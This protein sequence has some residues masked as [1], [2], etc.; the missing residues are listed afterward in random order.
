MLFAHQVLAL[1]GPGFDEGGTRALRILLL[2]QAFNLACGPV[3]N[4][5]MMSGLE[6]ILL[7]LSAVSTSIMIAL[8]VSLVVPFGLFGVAVGVVTSTVF[9]NVSVM[10]L[11]R[12]QLGLQWWNRRFLGWLAPA[13]ISGGLGTAI[14]YADVGLGAVALAA[15]LI[16]MY[17]SFALVMYIQG[18]NDDER[19]LLRD[20]AS[21]FLARPAD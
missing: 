16:A 14:L 2:G 18:F 17:A 8:T 10:T 4:I 15:T 9:I 6:R 1:F 19:D 7:R 20:I 13:A 3:G 12:R 5:A 21:R 11:I